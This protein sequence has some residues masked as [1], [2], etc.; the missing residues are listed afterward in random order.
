VDLDDVHDAEIIEIV[1]APMNPDLPV[2]APTAIDEVVVPEP[3]ADETAPVIP[4]QPDGAEV[5]AAAVS[6][7][8]HPGEA[9]VA[10]ATA[11]AVDADALHD[12]MQQAQM[13]FIDDPRGA[14]EAARALAGEALE[15]HIA[16]LR[17][18]SEQLDTWTGDDA[19]DTEVLRAAMRA[20]RDVI[21][22]LTEE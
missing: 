5:A 21:A 10:V 20:Y 7:G 14:T 15:A 18:R 22:S 16:A 19:P 6:G 2:P 13:T 17:A 3:A 8:M 4:T 12:R 9:D 11:T 1:P